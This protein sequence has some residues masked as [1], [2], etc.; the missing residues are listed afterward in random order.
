[1]ERRDR[2]D[3]RKRRKKRE[4]RERS[5]HLVPIEHVT[6]AVHVP[7]LPR[8]FLREAQP[9]TLMSNQV[10]TALVI[11]VGS[12]PYQR[13]LNAFHGVNLRTFCALRRD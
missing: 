6:I 11:P 13:T 12:H 1:M 2:R 4:R 7:G 8:I 3:R 10:Q 9:S 5:T